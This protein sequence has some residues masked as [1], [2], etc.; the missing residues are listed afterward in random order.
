MKYRVYIDMIVRHTAFV[1]IEADS[2]E[3]ANDLAWDQHDDLHYSE[4]S[5]DYE[6]R[7]DDTHEDGIKCV[8]CEAPYGHE[9]K[10]GCVSKGFSYEAFVTEDQ[11]KKE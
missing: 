8:E 4:H 10:A 3:K 6:S 11:C 9:H 2:P 7:W 5:V 1:V